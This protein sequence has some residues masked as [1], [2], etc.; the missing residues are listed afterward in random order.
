[1]PKFGK[2]YCL[3]TR[4]SNGSTVEFH[5]AFDETT[6]RYKIKGKGC[7]AGLPRH[8]ATAPTTIRYSGILKWLISKGLVA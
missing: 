8:V 7:P 6:K 3:V 4:H 1:M 2:E 5:V